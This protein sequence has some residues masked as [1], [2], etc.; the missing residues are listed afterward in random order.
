MPKIPDGFINKVF[1][2]AILPISTIILFLGIASFNKRPLFSKSIV[3][4]F[5]ARLVLSILFIC[6]YIRL[7]RFSTFSFYPNKKWTKTDIGPL[8]KYIL[9]SV[10]IL[11]GIGW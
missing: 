4:D 2:G 6:L 8:E 1:Y 7:S 11:Y 5:F 10:C 3:F 9:W